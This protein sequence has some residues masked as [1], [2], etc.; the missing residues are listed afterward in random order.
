MC[1][2]YCFKI[3]FKL[4]SPELLNLPE[5]HLKI[6][7]L[8]PQSSNKEFVS[9][10]RAVCICDCILNHL[11]VISIGCTQFMYDELPLLL[12]G[13]ELVLSLQGPGANA[14]KEGG[15]WVRQM[16]AGTQG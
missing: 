1:I 8:L 14:R 13:A 15:L 16:P 12:E 10:G 4:K 7:M 3:H 6:S 9:Q 11:H 5:L 2:L